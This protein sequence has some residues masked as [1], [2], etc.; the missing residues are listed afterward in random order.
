MSNR[1]PSPVSFYFLLFKMML[2]FRYCQNPG[3]LQYLGLLS[4]REPSDCELVKPDPIIFYNKSI[5][6]INPVPPA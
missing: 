1:E 3:Y 6:V 4:N 5:P 2:M